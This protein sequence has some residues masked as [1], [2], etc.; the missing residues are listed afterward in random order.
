MKNK[1]RKIKNPKWKVFMD[2][3]PVIEQDIRIPEFG[4]TSDGR[5][6][7]IASRLYKTKDKEKL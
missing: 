6:I 1:K 7:K 5:T 4:M 2:D 3:L